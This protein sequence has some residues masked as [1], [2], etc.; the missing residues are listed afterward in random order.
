MGHSDL[1]RDSCGG[2]RR[3]GGNLLV[4]N[5]VQ[6][7]ESAVRRNVRA[8]SEFWSTFRASRKMLNKSR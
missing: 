8:V 3:C 5:A 1:P 7:K 4:A 2:V 6:P